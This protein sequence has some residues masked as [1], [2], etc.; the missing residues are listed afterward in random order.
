MTCAYY[1]SS[2]CTC[3]DRLAAQR[4]MRYYVSQ[5]VTNHSAGLT[6]VVSKCVLLGTQQP[7]RGPTSNITFIIDLHQPRV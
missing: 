3:A 6:S 1:M 4:M 7:G 2:S 5:N